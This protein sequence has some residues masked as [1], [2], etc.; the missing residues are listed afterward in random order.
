MQVAAIIPFRGDPTILTWVLDGFLQQQLAPGT[1]LTIYLGA[2]GCPLPPIPDSPSSN[3]R[4]DARELPRLGNAA[5]KNLLLDVCGPDTDIILFANADTRPDPQCVQRHIDHLQTLPPGSLVL[6]AAPFDDTPTSP[7]VFDL[8]KSVTPMIF[9]YCLMAPGQ[10]YDFRHTW[11]LNL[12]I[13]RADLDSLSG[14][15]AGG[16]F[17]SQIFPFYEDLDLGFRLMGQTGKK[18]YYDDQAIVR[19]RHPMTLE[20]YLDREEMLGLI[21]PVVYVHNRPMFAALMGTDDLEH[22]TARFH[23]WVEM[24]RPTQQWVWTRLQEWVTQPATVLGSDPQRLLNTL[25]QMHIPLKRLAFR[26][27]FLR[28]LDLV[29]DSRKL[30]RT[31]SGLWR[32]ALELKGP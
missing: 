16:A 4:L 31:P 20:S 2:D 26:L 32:K 10:W 25:Y 9:F 28:G 29:P 12:S 5:G 14:G 19:H 13:R 6:G 8:L 24:D 23:T 21:M 7:T 11:T 17:S 15:G 30:E 1:Q 27:G 3:I 18:I 22:L